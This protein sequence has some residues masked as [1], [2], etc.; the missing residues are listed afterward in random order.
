MGK[1]LL[2]VKNIYKNNYFNTSLEQIVNKIRYS[3]A[4]SNKIKYF[5]ISKINA[6]SR[7]IYK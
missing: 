1:S 2:I 7:N 3:F 6:F 5:Q 4:K